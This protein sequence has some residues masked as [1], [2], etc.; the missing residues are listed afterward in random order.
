[1]VLV[2]ASPPVPPDGSPG[3]F[4]PLEYEWVAWNGDTYSLSDWT[5]GIVLDNRGVEGLHFPQ[6]TK[7]SS[8]SHVVPGKRLR[9]WRAEARTVFW[10]IQ[11]W[12]D[13]GSVEWLDRALR[14]FATLHPLREGRWR[15]GANG[16]WRELALTGVFDESHAYLMDPM[17]EGWAPFAVKLEAAHPFW[18]GK[19]VKAG[20][21]G[22]SDGV[23]FIDPGGA[24]SFHV[25]AAASFSSAAITNPGDVDAYPIWTLVGPLPTVSVGIGGR[26]IDVP[27]SVADG[28]TL[29]ID[30]DPRNVTATLDGADVTADL[31]FQQ[32]APIPPGAQASLDIVTSGAGAVSIELTPLYLRA[33]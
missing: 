1:M 6:I 31:G 24:P 21:W 9:G 13:A 28:E 3:A 10:P 16:Q 23:D 20:P 30:T 25:S 4:Q 5:S 15:V 33:F 26:V 2:F 7:F 19:P 32:F 11:I 17:L 27:F 8:T 22:L 14:F 18:T 12:S 29:R